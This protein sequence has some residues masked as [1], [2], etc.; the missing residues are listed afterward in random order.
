MMKSSCCDSSHLPFL[1]LFLRHIKL[2]DPSLQSSKSWSKHALLALVTAPFCSFS[3]LTVSL[4]VVVAPY[5]HG[6]LW[7][8]HQHS[9]TMLQKSFECPQTPFLLKQRDKAQD[10][11]IVM[12]F[13]EKIIKCLKAWFMK[14]LCWFTV[15]VL[16]LFND[17]AL[18]VNLMLTNII[19]A[20]KGA[21]HETRS[22]SASLWNLLLYLDGCALY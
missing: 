2:L 11:M 7:L 14:L 16:H 22:A 20:G 6:A 13:I 1:C 12:I 15:A 19:M 10:Y 3:H 8:M 18:I 17:K 9:S 21:G 4:D 5:M